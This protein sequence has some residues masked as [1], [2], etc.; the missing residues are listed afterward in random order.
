MDWDGLVASFPRVDF[1]FAYGSGV[2]AQRGYTARD[3]PMIDL[4]FAVADP[5]AW[6]KENLAMNRAH[7]ADGMAALGAPWIARLQEETGAG[8]YYNTLV[9]ACVPRRSLRLR[10]AG[11]AA[12]ELL[13]RRPLRHCCIGSACFELG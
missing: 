11:R 9:R 7:Y 2:F 8:L 6:H 5:A 12:S 13:Q 1:A 4:V 10:S 3:A